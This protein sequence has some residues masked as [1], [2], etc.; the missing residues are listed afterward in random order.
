L[1]KWKFSEISVLVYLSYPD[2]S[3]IDLVLKTSGIVLGTG[4]SRITIQEKSDAR[5][6]EY[7][8]DISLNNPKRRNMIY[9]A[10]TDFLLKAESI[11]ASTVGFYTTGL[12]AARIPSW[13]IAEELV[14]AV[15]KHSKDSTC[16]KE[17]LFVASSPTQMSSFQFALNNS[18]LYM[19]IE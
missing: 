15:M 17:I 16:I 10:A 14:R 5:N 19:F 1:V 7:W 8:P 11:S 9:K 18:N 12:E 2:D 4:K 13:E 6:I 3:D